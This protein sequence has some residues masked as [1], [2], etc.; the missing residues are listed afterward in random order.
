VIADEAQDGQVA[1]RLSLRRRSKWPGPPDYEPPPCA[2]TTLQGTH[3]LSL[4]AI[5]RSASEI[6][7]NP[8]ETEQTAPRPLPLQDRARSIAP[9][10][11]AIETKPVCE[12]NT[13]MGRHTDHG[14]AEE[15]QHQPADDVPASDRRIEDEHRRLSAYRRECSAP[16][17]SF[18]TPAAK[19][20]ARP[21]DPPTLRLQEPLLRR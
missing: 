10:S 3:P 20:A 17:S 12:T 5:E 13:E 21:S 11:A 7:D 14:A 6:V 9:V 2:P 15:R 19:M 18:P 4:Q 16:S 1:T 8:D